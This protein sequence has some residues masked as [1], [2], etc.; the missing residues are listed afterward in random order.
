MLPK[1]KR[2]NLTTDFKWVSSG[3]KLE[4]KYLKL[5]LR[6]GDDQ[7]PRVGIAVSGKSF[8]KATDRNRAKRVVSQAFESVYNQLPKR[9]NILALPKS[10]VLSVKSGDI[11]LDLAEKLR[12]EKIIN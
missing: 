9:V 7:I 6:M 11:L 1:A 12:Y 5:F 3:K 8:K 10:S 4:T 2:L